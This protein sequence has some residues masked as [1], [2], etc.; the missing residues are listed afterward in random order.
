MNIRCMTSIALAI[1]GAVSTS[2]AAVI[3]FD[4]LVGGPIFGGE[5]VTTQYAGLG[6]NFS[7]SYGGGAHAN[8]TLTGFISG[9]SPPNVVWVDQGSGIYSGQYLEVDFSIP[10]HD[11]ST[12]FGTSLGADITLAAYNGGSLLGLVNL[13][14]GT[15]IGDTRSGVVS[16]DSAQDITSVQLFSHRTGTSTSFNFDIDNFTINAVP[17][18]GVM[19]LFGLSLTCFGAWRRSRRV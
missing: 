8:N 10:V 2:T 9:S 15:I 18:P 6:V 17:E 13:V 3:D 12:V 4:N 1:A 19:A 14:G 7:D 11:V 16:F 5:L